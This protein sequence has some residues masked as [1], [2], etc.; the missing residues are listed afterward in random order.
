MGTGGT[1]G[2]GQGHTHS[3][4]WL[5]WLKMHFWRVSRVRRLR[6]SIMFRPTGPPTAFAAALHLVCGAGDV[7]GWGARVAWGLGLGSG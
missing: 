5:S 6:S 3:W 4:Q 1:L 2:W 7:R